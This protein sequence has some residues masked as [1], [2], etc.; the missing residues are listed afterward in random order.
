MIGA[1]RCRLWLARL[2]ASSSVAFLMAPQL[3]SS[4]P[5]PANTELSGGEATVSD[6]SAEAFG[7]PING[8]SE[9]SRSAFFVGRSFFRGNWVVAGPPATR[10]GLG[11]F[12]NARSC[13][14]CHGNDGRGRPPEAGQPLV[15]VLMR[16]SVPGFDPHRRPLPDPVYGGQIAGQAVPGISREADVVAAYT[17]VPGQFSDGESY[18]LRR[19]TYT[20]TNLGYGPLAKDALLSPRAAP[21][22]VGLGLL[23]AVPESQLRA[24]AKEQAGSGNG[25]NGRLNSVWDITAGKMVAGRFGWKAEQPS[26]LQQTAGAFNEDMGL[27]T[28]LLPRESYTKNQAEVCEKK[29]SDGT[30]D[31]GEKILQDVVLYSRTLAVPARRDVQNPV[32]LSGQRL[33]H[34]AGCAVC[35]VP[36]LVTGSS[37][38][39]QLAN[40]TIHPYTDLLL[41]DMGDELS[42]KR[43]VYDAGGNDWRTPPLW[44]IGL[45]SKVNKH[46][47]FL[48]DG[49]ARSLSE[50]ILWHG[51]EAKQSREN[52]RNM[53]KS[54]RDALLAFLNSL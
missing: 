38:I 11:P 18:T 8:L 2:F 25:I 27:T 6:A 5:V 36:T 41:H 40:Q 26:V 50:A 12:F 48:H 49:R 53:S 47:F 33:F 43:P 45:V 52:F 17:D 15:E 1:Q 44:G 51:G 13:S 39:P 37:D 28:S 14:A 22:M 34:Q 19:P 10:A 29:E 7:F 20:V 9:E 24:I 21:A 30:I 16:I 31:V 46:T 3:H 54:D 23:E 32:V 42:D 4:E 35:H